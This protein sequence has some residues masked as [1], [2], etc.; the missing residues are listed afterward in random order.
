MRV[1][2]DKEHIL[3]P[4][5]RKRSGDVKRERRYQSSE[6]LYDI[7]PRRSSLPDISALY[8]NT[9]VA[10]NS[11][12]EFQS[13]SEVQSSQ[14]EEQVSSRENADCEIS[15][16]N[17]IIDQQ[18]K[19][20]DS[21][22]QLC[23]TVDETQYL[24]SYVKVPIVQLPLVNQT[25]LFENDKLIQRLQD[26][27]RQC[28]AYMERHDS[29]DSICSLAHEIP[30]INHASIIEWVNQFGINHNSGLASILNNT[31][32][33]ESHVY[34]MTSMCSNH[35]NTRLSFDPRLIHHN[36]L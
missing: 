21:L 6:Q 3:D 34:R 1:L 23:K 28:Y 2:I 7:P 31:Q 33:Q 5:C 27:I 16:L 18:K 24:Q 13:T 25:M 4:T 9:D 15:K 35:S 26:K 22:K 17:A 11:N 10:L 8:V 19:L 29:K 12:L 36:P 20:I 14:R 30:I 32:L